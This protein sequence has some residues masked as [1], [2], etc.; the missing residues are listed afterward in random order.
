MSIVDTLLCLE[1]LL[2][3]G[4]V[5]RERLQRVKELWKP[6]AC[7]G[8]PS[9]HPHEGRWHNEDCDNHAACEGYEHAGMSQV[10][11]ITR[12]ARRS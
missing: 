7:S 4:P 9:A 12:T 8:I 10:S 6:I 11:F 2:S 1:R 5:Q 3:R